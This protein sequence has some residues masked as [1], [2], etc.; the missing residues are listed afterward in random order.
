MN[1]LLAT[2][3]TSG[4]DGHVK[5]PT[6]P[7]CM[8]KPVTPYGFRPDASPENHLYHKRKLLVWDQLHRPNQQNQ[9]QKERRKST[10]LS[11]I[12][13]RFWRENLGDEYCDYVESQYGSTQAP[14]EPEDAPQPGTSKGGSS[15]RSKD[16]FQ[17]ISAASTDEELPQNESRQSTGSN[18]SEKRPRED[19]DDD[20]D[21]NG[22]GDDDD[23]E[24]PEPPAKRPNVDEP[25]F[26]KLS[27]LINDN[28]NQAA[29]KLRSRPTTLKE[30]QYTELPRFDSEML[31]EDGP[32][33]GWRDPSEL[34]SVS[35]S[36]NRM[37]HQGKPVFAMSGVND[38][39]RATLV[40][41]I[42]QLGGLL[43]TKP[44]EYDK[45]C[46]HILCGKPNRG[47]K[48]L[49]GIAGGKWLLCIKYIEDSC[50]AGH[51]LD[52]EKYE[53][54]NPAAIDLPALEAT[55]RTVSKAA[56]NWRNRILREAGKHDG[57]FTGFRVLLL[58]PKKEQFIRL[59]QA[60]GGYVIDMDPPFDVEDLNATHCFVDVKK[61]KIAVSDHRVL[62]QAGIAVMSIMYLNAYLTSETLPDPAKHR[63]TL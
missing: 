34:E 44:N 30:T 37:R 46:T 49:S 29:A 25:N 38:Q 40:D 48:I 53:W 61:A 62:A 45:A 8:T 26:K 1:E 22:N 15:A 16:V 43:S 6:L 31:S 51:F 3:S 28:K 19:D 5:T 42:Q 32:G 21:G 58:A 47:E 11:E 24:G 63:L 33:V 60:G 57:V 14:V 4:Q 39:Q 7:D 35:E 20:N 9:Q 41:K 27:D 13:R 10:P 36:A 50:E 54:G 18:V 59:I 2:P 17:E 55:E 52:E 23:D 12:K 56:Y